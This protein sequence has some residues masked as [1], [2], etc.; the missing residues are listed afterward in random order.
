[1]FSRKTPGRDRFDPSSNAS[2]VTIVAK[3]GQCGSSSEKNVAP[4]GV[5]DDASRDRSR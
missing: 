1:M 4:F 2:P 5:A 3:F